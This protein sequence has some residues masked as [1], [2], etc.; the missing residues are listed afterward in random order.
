MSYDARFYSEWSAAVEPILL[1]WCNEA[2]D[3]NTDGSVGRFFNLDIKVI[4][5]MWD[6]VPFALQ[7]DH[8]TENTELTHIFP[9]IKKKNS[10]CY[11]AKTSQWSSKTPSWG[12]TS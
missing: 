11:I 3:I 7:D 4:E 9:N 6:N 12:I 10:M 5:Q 2:C 1:D 8:I